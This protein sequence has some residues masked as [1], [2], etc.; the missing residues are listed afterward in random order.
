MELCLML[1]NSLDGRGVWERMDTCRCMAESLFCPPESLTI[2]LTG[3]TVIQNQSL[4][5]KEWVV[6]KDEK[7]RHFLQSTEQAGVGRKETEECEGNYGTFLFFF[8]KV[9]WSI[10]ALQRCV[11]FCR[12]SK[13]L[14]FMYVQIYT[15]SFSCSFPLQCIKG[16]WIQSLCYTVGLCCLTILS[17]FVWIW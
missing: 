1:C 4:L 9:F 10:A 8:K 16:Y 6:G 2:L 13:A 3:Y 5:E 17:I 15:Y 12:T 7:N 14:S 11:N